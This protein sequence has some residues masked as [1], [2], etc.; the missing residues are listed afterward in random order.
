M[1]IDKC[2]MMNGKQFFSSGLFSRVILHPCKRLVW[3][4]HFHRPRA[5]VAGRVA[6]PDG[7][8]VDT[9]GAAAGTFGEAV[10]LSM[11]GA[12]VSTTVTVKAPIA[13]LP[14]ASVAEAVTVVV[15]SGNVLPG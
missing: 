15:P 1:T 6:A 3:H 2:Q 9:S 4:S 7:D 13:V 8:R 5:R 12:V 11:T 14:A 10:R